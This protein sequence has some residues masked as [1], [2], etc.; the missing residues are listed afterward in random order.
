[1]SPEFGTRVARVFRAIDQMFERLGL[2]QRYVLGLVSA[3]LP[4]AAHAAVLPACAGPAE[5]SN[6]R[7]VRVETNGVLVLEDGRA[8]K[9]EGLLLPAGSRDHAPRYLAD[10][11]IS[12]LSDL[13]RGRLVTL[14]AQWPKEDRYGR[15]RAQVFM[16][17]NVAQPWLQFEVLHRGLARVSIAPDRRECVGELYTAEDEARRSHNGIWSQAT[18]AVRPASSA[19]DGDTDTFQVVKGRILSADV[20]NGRGYLDFGTDWRHDFTVTISPADMKT[21]HLAGVDPQSYEGKT[22]RVRGWV[23]HLRRP[24]IEVA[25]PEDIE[26]LDPQ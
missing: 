23:E 7:V 25:G 3:L 24:E 12:V 13:V 18:Y 22:V 16:M 2:L 19:F 20:K 10:E 4:A 6:V 5:A 14:A 26:V 11:A 8:V 17:D 15:L 1:M 21:F 9:V